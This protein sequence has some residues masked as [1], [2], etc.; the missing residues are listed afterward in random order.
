MTEIN[1][2]VPLP[3]EADL[4]EFD[5]PPSDLT[6]AM[7]LAVAIGAID[8]LVYA[9]RVDGEPIAKSRA[10]VGRGRHYTPQRTLDAE[11]DIAATIRAR[12]PDL[13]FAGNVAI[14]VIF[15]RPNRHR[16]D[17]DNLLKTV[18]DGITKSRAVWEDDAHVTALAGILEYDKD[19]PRTIIA[20]GAHTSSLLRGE[21]RKTH[22]CVTCGKQFK[23]HSPEKGAQYCSR[24]CRGRRER[25]LL[26]CVDCGGPTSAPHV[27]RCR[28][29]AKAHRAGRS[30][31][32]H[33]TLGLDDC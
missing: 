27:Q 17:V 3:S 16:I 9:V 33:P 30:T 4:V 14:A 2:T 28:A 15:Y 24:K 26:I 23:P 31:R 7:G 6:R 18:L 1:F 21:N 10:R 22:I 11:A 20:I 13:P 25:G 29:C 19:A 5:R 32:T 12:Q 8:D